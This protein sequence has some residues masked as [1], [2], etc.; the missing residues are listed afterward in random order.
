[1]QKVIDRFFL[2]GLFP[3]LLLI[4]TL[5][6]FAIQIPDYGFY[7]DD[8]VSVAAFDQGGE[9]GLISYGVDDTRPFSA[10]YTAKVFEVIGTKPLHWQIFTVFWRFAAAIFCWLILRRIWPKER[11]SASIIA[12]LFGIFPFFKHQAL[13]IAYHMI[14]M[15]YA[16][17]LCSFYLTVLAL[18]TRR[19]GLKLL[20]FALSYGTSV[21]H[22]LCL[23][24]YLSLE[25]VRILL[26]YLVLST[27]DQTGWKERLVRTLKCYLPY[28]LILCGE[29]FYRFVWIPS[30]M[31]DLRTI[32]LTD[33]Y[34][35]IKL[36]LHVGSLILQYLSESVLGVWY[37]SINPSEID[38]TI[39]NTQIAF[40]MGCLVAAVSLF[41][42]TRTL[43]K[44][45]PSSETR[46]SLKEMMVVGGA[47]ALLGFLPG[48]AIDVSPSSTYR[49]HDRYLIPSFWGIALFTVAFLRCCL[50]PAWLRNA[51]ISLTIFI[52]V[53]FQI[54]NAFM[55]RYSWK[56]QQQFQWSMK[57]RIPDVEPNT[58]II[59]DGA[60]ASF[61]GG[62]ADGSMIFEMY[63]KNQG[64]TPTPYWYFN[65][66]DEN[67][68]SRLTAGEPIY[69]DEKIFRFEAKAENVIVLTKPEYGKCLWVLDEA[70]INNPY[71][72][73]GIADYLP[74]QNKDRIRYESDYQLPEAVFGT[75]YTHDWCYYFENAD[76]ALDMGNYETVLSL[77]REAEAKGLTPG[78]PTE[79]RPFIKAAAMTG[80]LEQAHAWT[81][82][83]AA[84]DPENVRPYFDGLWEIIERQLTE[85]SNP[86]F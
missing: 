66:A 23:E 38:L 78:N 67:W 20:F 29:F 5:S 73:S 43:E 71:L 86:V 6:A 25:A 17:I 18:Q 50:R 19:K 77:Y 54:Q 48:I 2:G 8:W 33:R 72:E 84:K 21:F 10:W 45:E 58:A 59:G 3:L 55:Y 62:W 27:R 26:I 74:F 9:E 42:L 68:V 63:G 52:A 75:D 76:R 30:M 49:Y 39:R 1:M 53:F 34:P 47:A 85:A 40:G 16:V 51:M 56:Y 24:Y 83:A 41:L 28:F 22:L 57:W 37:R 12:I 69:K 82:S 4:V 81:E 32:Q 11:A 13:C 31:N 7:L 64:I 61:M 80:D 79:M 14:L 46:K 70:D 44:A 15:Q 36:I 60:T 35:G 65:A